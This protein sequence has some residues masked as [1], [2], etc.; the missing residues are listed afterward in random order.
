MILSPRH[1]LRDGTAHATYYQLV[2]MRERRFPEIGQNLLRRGQHQGKLL[3]VLSALLS[4]SLLLSQLP[5]PELTLRKFPTVQRW[6]SNWGKQNDLQN[7]D[8][9]IGGPREDI[10]ARNSI[11][12]LGSVTARMCDLGHITSSLWAFKE[13]G[14]LD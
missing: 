10:I 13:R 4:Y 1:C 7:V 8:S 6:K 14:T 11:S 12:G 5:A 3:I 2:V 9:E